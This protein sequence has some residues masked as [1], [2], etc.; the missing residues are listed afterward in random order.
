MKVTLPI[1]MFHALDD[2]PSILS[3]SPQLFQYALA[4]LHKHGYQTLDLGEVADNLRQHKSFPDPSCVI[5]F[6]DGYQSVYTEAFPLLQ[7]YGMSA[8]VF[9]TVG[10]Q[11][12]TKSRYRLP[13][14][15]GRSMLSWGEI[16]EMQQGGIAFGAHTLTHPDLTRLSMEQATI[17]IVQSKEI[18]EDALSTP[19]TSFAYPF[20]YFDQRS[21][22]IVQQYF[23][24]ACSVQLGFITLQSDCY[25]LERIDTYYLR[26]ERLFNLM[27]TRWFPRYI[28]ARNIPRRWKRMVQRG[29]S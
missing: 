10:R 8:T 16:R 28:Q 22:A 14:M 27:F 19:V 11:K 7:R 29:I 4:S 21:Q 3:F 18:I 20:G 24:C 12:T 6:D 1:L 15:E 13:S 5:T 17:E 23:T 2:R 25:A 9:L 26:T